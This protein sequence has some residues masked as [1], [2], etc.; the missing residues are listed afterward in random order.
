MPLLLQVIEEK[1]V[2]ICEVEYIKDDEDPTATT[3]EASRWQ[4]QQHVEQQK[5]TQPPLSIWMH[6]SQ[7]GPPIVLM[8]VSGPPFPAHLPLVAS[9][10]RTVPHSRPLCQARSL[11]AEVAELFRSVVQLSVKLRETN[12]PSVSC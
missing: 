7:G 11:A 6:G 5:H 3:D 10:P 4:E 12:V 9:N 8:L 2:L 1:P